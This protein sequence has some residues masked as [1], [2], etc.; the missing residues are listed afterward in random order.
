MRRGSSFLGFLTI[1]VLC[2][3]PAFHVASSTRS[4]SELS[5]WDVGSYKVDLLAHNGGSGDVQTD[6][7]EWI[8][9]GAN[10]LEGGDI[11][12]LVPVGNLQRADIIEIW[13]DGYSTSN[14]LNIG[15]TVFIGTGKNRYEQI[16]RMT[17][18][19]WR[20]FVFRFADDAL[21]G[22]ATDPS[23]RNE[24]WRMRYPSSKYEVRRIDKSPRDLLDGRTLPI[25]IS[26]TGA[27]D[28]IIKRIEVVVWRDQKNLERNRVYI[29][30]LSP[31]KVRRGGKISLA[32]NRALPTEDVDFYILDPSGREYRIFPHVINADRNK[33]AFYTKDLPV[34][35]SG[36]YQVK[37]IDRSNQDQ[38]HTDIER[39]EIYS[40]RSKPVK[41]TQP[42]RPLP[43][44]QY[45]SA[46]LPP[47]P[48]TPPAY[49][50][51]VVPGVPESAPPTVVGPPI[52]SPSVPS[53]FIAPPSTI[54]P[55]VS[56]RPVYSEGFTIQIGAYKTQASAVSMVHRLNSYGFDAYI[57]ES[58]TGGKQLFRVRVG[59]YPNKSLAQRDADQLRS[60]GFDT[61]IATLR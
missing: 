15:P 27:E 36:R 7:N 38:E 26:V 1:A 58:V 61:W 31:Y 5:E 18:D 37:L 4:V 39:F 54:A 44:V 11:K 35:R 32:L 21:Y 29:V 56:T 46:Y 45:P 57:S 51:P 42:E 48:E 20:P 16:T 34:S 22:D 23:T 3:F 60:R 41:T 53:T 14:D 17:G 25:R 33:V 10:H 13:V 12:Y 52:A 43:T 19:A 8:H 6:Q 50:V 40:P 9:L 30:N 24:Y 59:R 2:I 49:I 28:F 55:S 47:V